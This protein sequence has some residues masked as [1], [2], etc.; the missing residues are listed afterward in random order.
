MRFQ[1]FRR[2]IFILCLL[3]PF[4][5]RLRHIGR[6][7]IRRRQV[8]L[9]EQ[10][11]VRIVCPYSHSLLILGQG[12]SL[13]LRHTRRGPEGHTL[14]ILPRRQGILLCPPDAPLIPPP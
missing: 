9:Q 7:I 11:V 8:I 1:H 6:Q 2:I 14:P 3:C 4:C 12:Y 10:V 5:S 13:Q